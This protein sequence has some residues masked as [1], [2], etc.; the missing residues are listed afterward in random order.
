[1]PAAGTPT[2]PS[3]EAPATPSILSVDLPPVE[4]ARLIETAHRE[5]GDADSLVKSIP[6]D[7][8]SPQ[9]QDKSRTIEGLVLASVEAEGRGDVQAAAILAHKALLLAVEMTSR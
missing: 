2:T 6:A 3:I 8:L 7:G 9:D 5:R 1:M 4:R